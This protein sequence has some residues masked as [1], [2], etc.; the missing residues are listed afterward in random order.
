MRKH[1][2]SMINSLIHLKRIPSWRRYFLGGRYE[3]SVTV[4]KYKVEF[5]DTPKDLE[6]FFWNA[7]NPCITMVLSKEDNVAVLN[8]LEYNEGC[9]IDGK[10]KRGKDTR[11]M[12]LFAIDLIK[13]KGARSVQL[14]DNSTIQCNGKTIRLGLMYFFKFGKTWYETL[15]FEPMNYKEEYTQ[16]KIIQKTLN[17]KN[18]PCDYFTNSVLNK[19][20]LQTGFVF[21]NDMSWELLLTPMS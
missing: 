10:M 16:A 8:R 2:T 6:M 18:Q 21:L 13:S 9:T 14:T 15:G 5:N 19:L 7:E 4:G 1:Q 3:D 11:D 12:I 17:L 20:I